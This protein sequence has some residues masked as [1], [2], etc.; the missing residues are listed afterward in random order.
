MAG[1]IV[2]TLLFCKKKGKAFYNIMDIIVLPTSLAVFLGRIANYI[3]SEILGIPSGGDW[4][5]IFKN[6]AQPGQL[7]VA[8]IP[9]Q[10]FES[11]KNLLIFSI[12][13]FASKR[14]KKPGMLAWLWV[15]L[16]GSFRFIIEFFKS[17]EPLFDLGAYNF[18]MGHVLCLAM[19]GASSFVLFMM[20]KGGDLLTTLPVDPAKKRKNIKKKKK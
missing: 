20:T 14:V 5:V 6:A 1:A 9:T 13:L 4:G 15:L 2:A 17:Y 10:L 19:I 7:N 16:Y 12:L 3:N 11:W 18:T 8:R